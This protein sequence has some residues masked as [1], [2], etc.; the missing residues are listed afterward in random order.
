[1]AAGILGIAAPAFAQFNFSAEAPYS[2]K[3]AARE[4]LRLPL[5]MARIT[6]LRLQAPDA[7]AIDAVRQA[8]TRGLNK[9]LQ[10]G[11]G[12]STE[13]LA[14]A[15]SGSL[16][17]NPAPGGWVAQW[18]VTSANASALRIGLVAARLLPGM[19]IR[20][21]GIREIDT[22][23][24]PFSERDVAAGGATYWSPV[25]EGDSATIEV[26]VAGT[27]SPL[28]VGLAITQVSHFLVSPSDANAEL[29][30]K[31]AGFCEVDLVC[32]S[33]TNAA[34]ASTGKAVAKMTFTENTGGTFLCTGTLLNAIGGS[35]TPYFYS[36]TH[37]IST[38][39]V[40]STLTTH[41]F[42][43][44]TGC[45]TGGTSPNYV[46]LTGG[47][48]LLYAND[49]FDALLL[50]LNRTPPAGAVFS[51]WDAATLSIG[52]ALTAVHHPAGDLKKVSLG[53]L[54]GFSSLDGTGT[55]FLVSNWT[56]PATGVTEGGSSGSGIFTSVGQPATEYR[57]RGGLWGGHSSCTLTANYDYYSRL[58][59]VYPAL[60]QYLNPA[61]VA[62]SY[63]LSPTSAI[64][65]SGA[66]TGSVGVAA[67]SGCAWTATSNADW[68]TTSSSGNGNGTV[69]YSVATN[70]TDSSRVGTLTI[71]GHPFTVTQQG[72]ASGVNLIANS[73]FETGTA[74][75]TE[76]ASGG[77][78]IITNDA[79]TSHSGAWHTWLGGYNDGTDTI[80]QNVTIPSGA[81]P[82]SLRFWYRIDTAEVS[83]TTAYDTLTVSVASPLTG[84][85]LATLASFANLNP[86]SGW[87]QSSAYDLS[88]F[89]GQTVRLA[90]KAV[91]DIS[92]VTNF[93]IDD[94]SLTAGAASANYTALWW[95]PAESGWGIN[96]AHQGDVI[97]ATWFTYDLTGK[98]WWLTMT[99]DGMPDGSYA[100]TLYQT[101]GPAFSAV[102]FSPAAVTA[103]P[104]GSGTLR[105]SDLNN[106]TF[107]YVVNGS[108]QVKSITR[109]V[110]GPVPSCVWGAQPNLA[111]ATNFQ[112]L[113]WAAP[114]GVE[115]GWGI[116]FT[117]QGTTV[118]A[119]WFTY[120]ADGTPLWLSVTANNTSPGV[121][122][123]TLYLTTGPP[124]NA[125][126]FDPNLVQRTVAGT[127]T[128]S[129]ANGNS[130]TLSYSV[131]TQ[132]GIV[133][134]MKSITRQVFRSPGTVCR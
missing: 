47:A 91:M 4:S 23:Y 134:Q 2:P 13:A 53:T 96:F 72:A 79:T 75:W 56:S 125:V 42:Y 121:Y 14:E 10:I 129:F 113:W 92:D 128:L 76:S 28:D 3:A 74:S 73:G 48:T 80:Y 6:P 36:A 16:R 41:W 54:G 107:T 88:A 120:N 58:D 66:A 105:F 119:T 106:G 68:L 35:F 104:V 1:V 17:W 89:K 27:E 64:V 115:S 108:Q 40:A 122:A 38:Q 93:R 97:F 34:L 82:V 70:A 110:F 95:N 87:V 19:E 130:G 99:A 85:T 86:T 101:H 37:C 103:T 124:F 44:R 83:A 127:A 26:F 52:T 32:R 39:S 7:K 62:C 61:N 57:L 8:N 20:F 84:A 69:N 25:L 94:I 132:T 90:F 100:G 12:R 112:D 43:D 51:G 50:R 81:G 45:G 77:Y 33:A 21:T 60:A 30:A 109:Q 22:V 126:P 111:A 46:Q 78:A 63:T 59:Q 102:P 9:R 55:N 11:I 18:E 5:G 24:G 117:Q 98:A 116:N 29:Q 49:F 114:A 131:N 31:A 118:F 67:T 71:G 123:G 15:W 65:G 133:A